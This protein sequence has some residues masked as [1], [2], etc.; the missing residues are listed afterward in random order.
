MENRATRVINVTI[1]IIKPRLSGHVRS[2]ENFRISEIS[3]LMKHG[4]FA[5]N[6]YVEH[7]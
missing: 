3:V 2:R 7:K 4:L 5:P 6:V 1:K